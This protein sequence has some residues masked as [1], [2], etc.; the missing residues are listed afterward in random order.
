MYKDSFVLYIEYKELFGM[1]RYE[2]AGR[3]IMAIFQYME[4]G[5]EPELEGMAKIAFDFIR[6]QLD[7]NSSKEAH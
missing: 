4:T 6:E 2:E 3:L 1:L 5:K 7:R